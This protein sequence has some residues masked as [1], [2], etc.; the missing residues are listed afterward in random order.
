MNCFFLQLLLIKKQK[1]FKQNSTRLLQTNKNVIATIKKT[2]TLKN[3]MMTRWC[4]LEQFTQT[5]I[6]PLLSYLF[7]QKKLIAWSIR[8]GSGVSPKSKVNLI[9]PSV[10]YNLKQVLG[11]SF[12]TTCLHAILVFQLFLVTPIFWLIYQWHFWKACVSISKFLIVATH[13]LRFHLISEACL[14]VNIPLQHFHI[15]WI[16]L[17][18]RKEAIFIGSS[19]PLHFC[20]PFPF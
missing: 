1:K 20:S 19:S 13:S 16:G 2:P 6:N 11:H 9:W 3:N 8:Q 18:C 4:S 5:L 15:K 14:D 7:L 17:L 10:D 12:S